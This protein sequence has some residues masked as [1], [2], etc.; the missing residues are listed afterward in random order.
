MKA[1]LLTPLPVLA[2]APRVVALPVVAIPRGVPISGAV[3]VAISRRGCDIARA[4]KLHADGEALGRGCG[5]QG[6]RRSGEGEG[7]KTAAGC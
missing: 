3:A 4:A 6:K 2:R 5:R 1:P 7:R